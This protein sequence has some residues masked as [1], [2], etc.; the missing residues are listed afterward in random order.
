MNSTM[1][2]TLT[3]IIAENPEIG[4][5]VYEQYPQDQKEFECANEKR[6]MDALRWRMAKKILLGTWEQSKKEYQTK[7]DRIRNK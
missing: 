7:I 3:Q 1:A 2:K 4:K 5:R 6:E